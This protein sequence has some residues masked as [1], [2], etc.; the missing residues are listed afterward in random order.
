M[1]FKDSNIFDYEFTDKSVSI[2]VFTDSVELTKEEL[3]QMIQIIEDRG[4]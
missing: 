1:I 4:E 3:E 2:N